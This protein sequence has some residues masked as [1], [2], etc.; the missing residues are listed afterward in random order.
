MFD[1]VKEI[2]ESWIIA[3]NPTESQLKLAEERLKICNECDKKVTATLGHFKC[4]ECGCPISK[5]IFSPK[6]DAC[7]LH[8]WL[9]V[10]DSDAFGNTRKQ[11]NTLI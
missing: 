2:A 8:K 10:E 3:N 5:K 9:D 11:Q 7:P 1:K 4:S 6:Y